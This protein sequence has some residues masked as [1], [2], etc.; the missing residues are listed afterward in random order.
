MN[1]K[2]DS[3][4]FSTEDIG[5]SSPVNRRRFPLSRRHG[6]YA[7]TSSRRHD[8]HVRH[9]VT[10]SRLLSRHALMGAYPTCIAR[11][12]TPLARL[13]LNTLAQ[14]GVPF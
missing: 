7:P 5:H 14:P 9:V 11:R 12:S 1:D 6:R 3:P 8:R 4:R 10:S 13:W 2:S